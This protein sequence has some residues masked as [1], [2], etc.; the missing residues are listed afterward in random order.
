MANV[1]DFLIK[2][3]A[4]N[5][6]V[7]KIAKEVNSQLDKIAERAHRV[8][9]KIGNSLRSA[10]SMGNLKNSI[11]SMPGMQFLTNPY[12]AIGAGLSAITVIGAKAEQ[13]AVSFET[14]VGSASTA[15]KVLDDINTFAARTPFSNMD[16]IENA[17]QML[18]FGVESENVVGYLQ[19][20]GDIAGGDKNKL[21]S[22]ALVF[23]QVKSAGKLMGQ[24]LMQMIGQGFNPLKELEVMTGK[25]YAELQDMMSKGQIGFEAVAAAIN[26]AT[27]E[28]GQFYNMSNKLADTVSGK[29]ST[30]TGRFEQDMVRLFNELEP[31]ILRLIDGLSVMMD[32]A[33]GIGRLLEIFIMNR[34]S[35]ILKGVSG[36]GKA[37]QALANG[38]F[39]GASSSALT[40]VKNLNPLKTWGD[41]GNY[42]KNLYNTFTNGGGKKSSNSISTPGLSGS[43]TV[44]FGDGTGG[45]NGGGKSGAIK[46]AEALATGGT[47]NTSITM[48][49]Q[50]FFDTMNVQMADAA[51]T[52]EM[53]RTVVQCMN[54][55][56]AI[57]TSTDR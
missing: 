15:K 44:T 51:D 5:Q 42:Y 46:T 35:A 3:Q 33:E 38:D 34:I 13:T 28:E 55:A 2:L 25:T 30:I 19:Q 8:S 52:S 56:L 14:L 23:G 18:S 7:D 6:N 53:E 10:F 21:S 20:L 41:I 39:D 50:K 36:I 27:S 24:D 12:V 48:T 29:W 4:K 17:K 47:R 43:N 22:L 49:I 31:L 32:Y 1:I 57:A 9:E 54:R 11:M 26:H 40:A 16:L 37:M 45:K